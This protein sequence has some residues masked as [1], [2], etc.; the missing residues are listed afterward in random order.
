[1]YFPPEKNT[2]FK[3][4]LLFIVIITEKIKI[5]MSSLLSSLSLSVTSDECDCHGYCD[6]HHHHHHRRRRRQKS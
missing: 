4:P 6:H 3:Y 5:I 1:M 2:K